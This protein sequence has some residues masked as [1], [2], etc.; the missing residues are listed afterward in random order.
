MN[1][2]ENASQ[3]EQNDIKK[4]SY[5]KKALFYTDILYGYKLDECHEITII[6]CFC[7]VFWVAMLVAKWV[8]GE[9]MI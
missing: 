8:L 7:F 2:Y 6:Q 5:A 1:V 3:P 4:S 9:I